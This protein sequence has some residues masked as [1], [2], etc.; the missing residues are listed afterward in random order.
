MSK[1]ARPFFLKN[2]VARLKHLGVIVTRSDKIY[3]I[4]LKRSTYLVLKI[5]HGKF[6]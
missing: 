3:Y 4:Q 2:A 6:Y 5:T 1:H